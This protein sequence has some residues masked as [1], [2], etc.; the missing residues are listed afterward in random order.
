MEAFFYYI[1]TMDLESFGLDLKTVV[2]NTGITAYRALLNSLYPNDFEY[3][4]CAFEVTDF[5]GETKELF[6][7]PIMPNSIEEQKSFLSNFKKLQNTI[8]VQSNPSFVPSRITVSGSFGK[9]LRLLLGRTV[10]QSTGISFSIGKLGTEIKTGY[11]CTK[12]LEKLIN[13]YQKSSNSLLFFYNLALGNN[14]LVECETMSFQQSM[15]NNMMW[16]YSFTLK[17]IA[18]AEDLLSGTNFD[19]KKKINKLLSYDVLNKGVN[20]LLQTTRSINL[21]VLAS[22][23]SF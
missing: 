7:F 23:N 19:S 11:G 6:I 15:E 10:S 8:I 14:Y 20:S 3:H 18:R 13:D 22:K 17:S 2:N 12:I 9:K 5:S 21:S 16:N 1:Y 4:L